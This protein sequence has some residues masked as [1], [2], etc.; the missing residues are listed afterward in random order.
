MEGFL[1]KKKINVR[2]LQNDVYILKILDILS[3]MCDMMEGY[4]DIFNMGSHEQ[5]D[6]LFDLL[7]SY[8]HGRDG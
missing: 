6:S 8:W 5:V 3:R 7:N 1:Y 2:M 4:E